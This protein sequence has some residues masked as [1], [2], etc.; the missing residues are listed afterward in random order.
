M[1]KIII[2]LLLICCSAEG[3]CFGHLRDLF[4][5]DSLGHPFPAKHYLTH[6]FLTRDSISYCTYPSPSDW[7][8]PLSNE[9]LSVY[10]EAAFREWT[11]GTA[12]Y[13]AKSGRAE[14]FEDIIALLNKPFELVNKGQCREEWDEKADI[15][16]VADVQRKDL[17]NI[18]AFFVGKSQFGSDAM[19][20]IVLSSYKTYQALDEKRKA[21]VQDYFAQTLA[22]TDEN[23]LPLEKVIKNFHSPIGIGA[24]PIIKTERYSYSDYVYD[25]LLHEVGH[26]FG[27]ADECFDENQ[28]SEQR[29]LSV[30]RIHVSGYIF[31]D[32]YS[33]PY[34]GNGIMS[35]SFNAKRTADDVM[36]LITILDR[37]T[38]TNRIIYPLLSDSRV[39]EVGAIVNGVYKYPPIKKNRT[40]YKFHKEYFSGGKPPFV[41]FK[42]Y[43]KY[44]FK[45]HFEPVPG[46]IKKYKGLTKKQE[47]QRQ[48]VIKMLQTLQ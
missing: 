4:T 16:I 15:E 47:L 12:A 33:T 40:A 9:M 6:K 32:P 27:L 43:G 5:K 35:Y 26:A 22:G 11:R 37:F 7:E 48:E 14:E 17:K 34:V 1:R 45:Q 18:G 29:S 30:S 21:K 2:T 25:T 8:Y 38:K 44:I 20:G 42:T 13:L 24:V 36:G 46:Y 3:F 23:K 19:V 31:N 41:H 28:R 10:F 39:P